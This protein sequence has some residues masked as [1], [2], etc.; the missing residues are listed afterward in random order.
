M[1]V[2]QNVSG[3]KRDDWALAIAVLGPYTETAA[4]TLQVV[5]SENKVVH[6]NIMT[7]HGGSR[8]L[9]YGGRLLSATV[10]C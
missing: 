9:I 8:W 4:N 10:N 5:A 6:L 7:S 3:L 2:N 1:G